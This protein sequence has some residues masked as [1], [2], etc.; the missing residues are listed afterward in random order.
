[1]TQS[2]LHS[3]IFSLIIVLM[4]VDVFAVKLYG[5]ELEN[6][7]PKQLRS[8]VKKA[9]GKVVSEG[10]KDRWYDIYSSDKL[11]YG[12]Q[13][14]YLGFTKQDKRFAF[15]EYEFGNAVKDKM[16][17][18]LNTRY[19]QAKITRGFFLSDTVYKWSVGK[20]TIK[21]YYDFPS[22]V[23]RLIYEEPQIFAKLQAEKKQFKKK[24]ADSNSAY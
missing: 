17:A 1:M 2:K 21:W 20:I 8:A 5:I 10:G 9:G 19:G 22:S 11:L 15:L 7:T 3:F 23:Y 12:S 16:L 18:K 24:E 13:K 6:A 4:S 14:V